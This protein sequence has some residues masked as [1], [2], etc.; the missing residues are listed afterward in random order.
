MKSGSRC[1]GH[2]SGNWQQRKEHWEDA[3]LVS[4]IVPAYCIMALFFRQMT[5]SVIAQSYENWELCIADGSGKD[6]TELED[7][8]ENV[9]AGE[10]RIRYRLLEE[11]LGISGNSDAALAMAS[12][13][14]I[15]LLDH[16]DVLARK[17]S[18][19]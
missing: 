6:K 4:I 16:D 1:T 8:V 5:D 13:D 17:H 12:G 10:K 2:F 11:N 18:M 14:I 9:Y 7:L 19:R 3:P 15:A